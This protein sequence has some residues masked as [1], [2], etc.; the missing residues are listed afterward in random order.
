[1]G[2]GEGKPEDMK[3]KFWKRAENTY[4]WVGGVLVRGTCAGSAL[5]WN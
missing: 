1:M 3:G 5:G 4:Q 2:S